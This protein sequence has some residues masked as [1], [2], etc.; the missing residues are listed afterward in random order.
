VGATAR[1]LIFVS[2]ISEKLA[3]ICGSEAAPPMRILAPAARNAERD[4]IDMAKLPMDAPNPK[5]VNF[6]YMMYIG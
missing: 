5:P 6:H 2:D 1:T 4:I 3:T